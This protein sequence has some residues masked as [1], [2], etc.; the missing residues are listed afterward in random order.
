MWPG[1]HH[2]RGQ[3]AVE[4]ALVSPVL[5]LLLLGTADFA[6]A[7][8]FNQE[9]VAAAR[10]GAQYGCQSVTTAADTSGIQAAALA[11]GVNVSGLSA[12]SSVCT[13]QSPAPTG[14]TSCGTGY[15]NGANSTATYVT[16]TTTATFRTL[17]HYPGVPQTANLSGTAIMQV[18][19]EGTS[20]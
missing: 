12:S 9:V 16:V 15:C 10:A 17:V 6:R 20:S 7:F 3:A 19:N 2:S 8:Y 11:N 18:I 13:C 4:L 1:R 5:G 14:E